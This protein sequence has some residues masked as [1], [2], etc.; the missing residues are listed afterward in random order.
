M[1]EAPETTVEIGLEQVIEADAGMADLVAEF[2]RTRDMGPI[3]A[4]LNFRV[5]RMLRDE[6]AP[7]KPSDDTHETMKK[8]V[9]AVFS[10]L[11]VY[12]DALGIDLVDAVGEDLKS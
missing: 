11:A 12:A 8:R 3:A 10:A 9:V 7:N 1:I 2:R 6:A 4:T 5:A